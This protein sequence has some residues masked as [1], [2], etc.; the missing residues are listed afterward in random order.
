MAPYLHYRE[1]SGRQGGRL[2]PTF[3][4]ECAMKGLITRLGRAALLPVAAAILLATAAAAQEA[5]QVEITASFSQVRSEPDRKA[6]AV[7]LVYGNDTVTVLAREGDWVRVQVSAALAGWVPRSAV[8]S[9]AMVVDRDR[10]ASDLVRVSLNRARGLRASGYSQEA[11]DILMQ[12]LREQR[13]TRTYYEAARYLNLF[14]RVGD[15]PAPDSDSGPVSEALL[16]RAE[17]N[18]GALLLA[19]GEARLEE[20]RYFAAVQA[21]QYALQHAPQSEPARIGLREALETYMNSELQTARQEELGLAVATFRHY[22]P[23]AEL[24][25]NVMARL[26]GEARPAN[27]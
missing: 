1:R 20:E 6:R 9:V 22:F 21:Y 14:H 3:A 2:Q 23:D 13:G 18:E 4:P 7:G 5:E 11:R 12:L 19:E 15:L 8:E 24:P 27:G 26:R 25:A 16:A 17:R 10:P